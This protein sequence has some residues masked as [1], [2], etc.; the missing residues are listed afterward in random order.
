MQKRDDD[1]GEGKAAN[2]TSNKSTKEGSE[3][4]RPVSQMDKLVAQIV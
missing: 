1:G 3:V 4:R 2:I